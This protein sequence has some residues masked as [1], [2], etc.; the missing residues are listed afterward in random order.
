MSECL[1]TRLKSSVNDINL[2][3]IGE[4]RFAKTSGYTPTKDN[5][6]VDIKL[7]VAQDVTVRI[8]NDGVFYV[9]NTIE[10]D[11]TA[12]KIKT[13]KNTTV[14]NFWVSPGSIVSVLYKY[15]IYRFYAYCIDMNLSEMSKMTNMSFLHLP[16]NDTYKNNLNGNIES[17]KKLNNLTYVNLLKSNINGDITEAFGSNINLTSLHLP[18]TYVTGSLN[19]F[20]AAQIA[21]GRKTATIDF[22]WPKS[23][24]FVTLDG[25]VLKNNTTITSNSSTTKLSWNENGEI[26][27]S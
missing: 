18:D 11:I 9:S 7:T 22:M 12:G 1:I 23:Y 19:D 10:E 15:D 27:W 25:I 16:V 21:A 24:N 5:S 14:I 26:T 8:L 2:R 3:K 20:V 13:F 4:F 6:Y 17:L